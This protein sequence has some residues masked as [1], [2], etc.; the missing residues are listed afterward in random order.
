MKL[1]LAVVLLLPFPVSAQ[2][3][4]LRGQVTDQTGAA[5]A[6]ATVSASAPGH[7]RKSTKSDGAGR[8]L[9]ADLAPGDYTVNASAPQLTLGEPV[10]AKLSAGSLTLNLVLTVAATTEKVTV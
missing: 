5:V 1:C 9:L 4:S 3:A 6:G 7:S 2:S 8:Y 10:S